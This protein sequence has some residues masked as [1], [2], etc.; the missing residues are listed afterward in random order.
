MFAVVSRDSDTT[1]P[2]RTITKVDP[3][4]R[5]KAPQQ[6]A[7]L[8]VIY[9]ADIGRRIELGPPALII[10][11]SSRADLQIDEESVSRQHARIEQD[12]RGGYQVADMGST[13][14]TYVNDVV[15]KRDP[16]TLRHGDQIQVG[17]SM[18]KFLAGGHIE[19]AYHEEIYRLMTTDG[20]TQ[21][22][23]R[24]AFEDALG[25]ELTR[26]VR[27]AR[28]LAVCLLDVDRFKGINDSY[29]HLA[30]DAILRQIGAILRANLR[31]NDIAGRL[32][33]E[34]FGVIFPEVDAAGGAIAAE[35]IRRLVEQHRFE[36]DNTQI[37][38]TLSA[39]V[40]G[41]GGDEADAVDVIRR[42]D[43]LLY[44]AKHAGRNCV[45]SA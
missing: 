39:G 35:K 10:G 36:F 6:G 28:P 3:D 20:L 8:V 23:N 17:R 13:N 19:S 14:G 41:R 40:A 34:E 11:R 2:H 22:L 37:P 45:K 31:K 7:C 18:L 15:I 29:G 21:L 38:V 25:K 42:A 1:N 26:A 30:G 5:P 43:E 33:G 4:G 12:G 44:E 32:G 16:T 24:R 27:H 9:G